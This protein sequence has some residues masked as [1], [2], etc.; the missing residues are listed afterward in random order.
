MR[1]SSFGQRKLRGVSVLSLSLSLSLFR[2]AGFT[3]LS[4]ISPTR[5][6]PGAVRGSNYTGAI[7]RG[8]DRLV[9]V[10]SP[11]DNTTLP[12]H[13]FVSHLGAA[14]GAHLLQAKRPQPVDTRSME[15][16]G[17]WEHAS[18]GKVERI[19]TYGALGNIASGSTITL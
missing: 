3:Y 11:T 7:V 18:G 13:G 14:Q 10:A 8:P 17:A 16:V 19:K 4:P 9:F 12:R 1:R 15:G 5:G 6:V 2:F